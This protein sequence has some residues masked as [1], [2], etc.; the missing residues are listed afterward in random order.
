MC[1]QNKSPISK[2]FRITFFVVVCFTTHSVTHLKQS[3]DPPVENRCPILCLCHSL[4]C[5]QMTYLTNVFPCRS[6]TQW[7]FTCHQKNSST[8]WLVNKN[9]NCKDWPQQ[10]KQTR[11]IPVILLKCICD[12]VS[13]S[14]LSLRLACQV[15]TRM[16]VKEVSCVWQCWP[17]AVQ[18]TSAP[19]RL[20]F[21]IICRFLPKF[22]A[23]NFQM[24]KK[25]VC[26]MLYLCLCVLG[27]CHP[28]FKRCVAAYRTTMRWSAVQRSL[29]LGSFLNTCRSD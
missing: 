1:L 13:C 22:I 21:T 4:S 11:Y 14:C 23:Q 7:L 9:T 5:V 2:T 16:S 27:C 10:K 8:S 12:F 3:Y 29:P 26:S 25:A 15:R 28:C 20:Y 17:R 18:I 24:H 19:S 6:L